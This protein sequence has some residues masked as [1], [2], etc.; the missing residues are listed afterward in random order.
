MTSYLRDTKDFLN[1]IPETVPKD[2]IFASFDIESLYS[3]IP[4]ALCLK[5]VDYSLEKYPETLNSRFTK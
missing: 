4:N 2:T 5:A 1:N 3:N